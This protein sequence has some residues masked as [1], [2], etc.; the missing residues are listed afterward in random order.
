MSGRSGEL[1]PLSLKD[2]F[3]KQVEKTESCWLWVGTKTK[4]G[5]GKIQ[6]N[7]KTLLAHRIAWYLEYGQYPEFNACHVCDNP[8]CV[9]VEHLY[10]ATQKQ[11]IA[12]KLSKNRQKRFGPLPGS[13]NSENHPQA[14]LTWEQVRVIRELHKLGKPVKEIAYDFSLSIGCVYD[15]LAHRTWRE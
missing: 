5:Y 12:D 11:N 7:G 1:R 8:S 10:D 6:L 14:R 4:A 9:R 15:L 3:W 2:R 13:Q